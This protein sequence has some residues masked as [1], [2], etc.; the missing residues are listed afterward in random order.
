M[1]LIKIFQI[2]FKA[3][4]DANIIRNII[5]NNIPFQ[6]RFLWGIGSIFDLESKIFDSGGVKS[7]KFSL[8]IYYAPP[9]P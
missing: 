6:C 2:F 9:P 5:S 4:L 7:Q 1:V 3:L 8:D